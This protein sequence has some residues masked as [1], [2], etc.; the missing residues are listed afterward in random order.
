MINLAK[1]DALLFFCIGP[2]KKWEILNASEE[3]DQGSQNILRRATWNELLFLHERET[4]LM[5]MIYVLYSGSRQTPKP[6]NENELQGK[7][8]HNSQT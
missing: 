2:Q 1:R 4:E 3:M 6:H 7:Y 8:F 5:P